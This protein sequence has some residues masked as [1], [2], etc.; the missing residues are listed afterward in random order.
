MRMLRIENIDVFYD[1]VQ[2]LRDVSLNVSKDDIVTIIGANGAGKTTLLK[3]ICGIL[4]PRRGRI[5]FKGLDIS[6]LD[7]YKIVKE[8]ISIVPEG[9]QL[10]GPLIVEDNLILG[11]Y[12]RAKKMEKKQ[13][14]ED[15]AFI[16]KLFPILKK[17]EKQI[18]STLSGGEQQMLSIARAFMANPNLILLDEPSIGLAPLVVQEIFKVLFSFKEREISMLLIE[19]NANIALNFADRAYVLENGKVILYGK[20]S[21]LKNNE[22]VR[23]AYL[24]K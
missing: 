5:L 15:L 12:K 7:S 22:D 3:A 20:S 16:Y 9:R 21:D 19:Q 14:V 13:I 4:H 17:R 6:H 18:S 24:G 10:F 2:V 11:T 8:G 1:N 23:R